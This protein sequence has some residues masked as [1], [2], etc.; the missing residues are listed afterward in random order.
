MESAPTL[1][2]KALLALSSIPSQHAHSPDEEPGSP[3]STTAEFGDAAETT[4]P[5]ALELVGNVH[6]SAHRSRL[7]RLLDSFI[8]TLSREG[9]DRGLLVSFLENLPL[10][11][12]SNL[13]IPLMEGHDLVYEGS[14][15]STVNETTGEEPREIAS[16]E[17]AESGERQLY[18]RA[19]ELLLSDR[20]TVAEVRELER[21]LVA[22]G[23][24]AQQLRDAYGPKEEEESHGAAGGE[25]KEEESRLAGP[26]VE[27]IATR[28][29]DQEGVW[30]G[31][32]RTDGPRHHSDLL[33]ADPAEER[34][35]GH[36]LQ[37]FTQ[38]T[39]EGGLL[40]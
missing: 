10:A 1:S 7:D 33:V 6:A 3:S 35:V 21:E 18:Q 32:A 14:P 37:S 28:F 29:A 31:W 23:L 5:P 15:T 38:P 34:E 30:S 25:W 2:A 26:S 12:E 8:L 11:N 36:G 16:R 24:Y 19:V 17:W 20:G 39:D 40:P 27:D 13:I 9:W 4:I 22:A